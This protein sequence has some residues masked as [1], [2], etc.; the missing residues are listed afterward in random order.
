MLVVPFRITPP[1][2]GVTVRL[3]KH[4]GGSYA[5]HVRN[6][7]AISARSVFMAIS[8]AVGPSGVSVRFGSAPRS[9]SRRTISDWLE[10]I[11]S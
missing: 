8:S 7:S 10:R 5:L 11:A 1:T 6:C 3:D 2:G 4:T 9:S